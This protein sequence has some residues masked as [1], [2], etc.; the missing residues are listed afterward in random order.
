MW[1]SQLFELQLQLTASFLVQAER[2][3]LD[4]KKVMERKDLAKSGH[5]TE[6]FSHQCVHHQLR[7]G[8][9]LT[10]YGFAGP[11]HLLSV[12]HRHRVLWQ[13]SALF[14]G[15]RSLAS[16]PCHLNFLPVAPLEEGMH[17]P[18]TAFVQRK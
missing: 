7:E 8:R 2:K 14:L 12:L 9:P 5:P 11:F 10:F 1:T 13:E 16:G 15:P 4:G 18:G 17:G 6:M 3:Y